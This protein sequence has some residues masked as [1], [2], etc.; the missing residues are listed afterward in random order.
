MNP[1]PLEVLIG[2]VASILLLGFVMFVKKA[3]ERLNA[4]LIAR[5]EGWFTSVNSMVDAVDKIKTSVEKLEHAFGDLTSTIQA[6]VDLKIQ[7]IRLEIK[8]LELRIQRIEGLHTPRA[9]EEPGPKMA[10]RTIT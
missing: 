2:A 1:T 8:Q 3:A 5:I 6:D 9:G 4:A 10:E 7:N